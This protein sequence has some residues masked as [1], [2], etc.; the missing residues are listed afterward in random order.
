MTVS[1]AL[2]SDTVSLMHQTAIL[3][4]LRLS[5]WLTD[6]AARADYVWSV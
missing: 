6:A 1:D 2:G 3:Q 5:C 4:G